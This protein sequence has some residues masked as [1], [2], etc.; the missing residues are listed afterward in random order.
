VAAEAALA[1]GSQGLFFEMDELIFSQQRQITRMLQD[2]AA[3]LGKPP[4]Q[5][6]SE[7]IQRE[8][9]IDLGGQLGLDPAWM[10]QE[11]ESRVH[12]PRIKAETDEAMRVGARG[13]P[14]SFINGRYFSGALPYETFRAEVQK[15][16]DWARNGNRPKFAA[17]TNV[18]QIKGKGEQQQRRGPDPDKVYDLKVGDAPFE[19]PAGAKVTVLHYLDYQ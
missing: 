9:F 12:L 17:G 3:S 16:V 2:K 14:A 19:G 1:A 11:L 6:R 4:D 7:D 15:E 10:R 13:T 5:A 18:S 8:V